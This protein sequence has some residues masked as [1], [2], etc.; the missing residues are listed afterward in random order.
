MRG[1]RREGHVYVT[2]R[3]IRDFDCDLD[4]SAI[5]DAWAA[6][7]GLVRLATSG[8]GEDLYFGDWT[9]SGR[10]RPPSQADPGWDRGLLVL[11]RQSEKCHVHLEAWVSAGAGGFPLL[12][13]R[14]VS[15]ESG[16]RGWAARS[17]GRRIVDDLLTN[18][19][20]PGIERGYL[21]RPEPSSQQGRSGSGLGAWFYPDGPRNTSGRTSAGD[22]LRQQ[23]RVSDPELGHCIL[24]GCSRW[25]IACVAIGV[26]V[27][28]FQVASGDLLPSGPP[29]L[30]SQFSQ[31]ITI[32]IGGLFFVGLAV[33]ARATSLLIGER[34]FAF[35]RPFRS[36]QAAW[37]NVREV[38]IQ[39][40]TVLV[41]LDLNGRSRRV[42]L[43]SDLSA[44][45]FVVAELMNE[46][47]GEHL[48]RI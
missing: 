16:M 45:P 21:S 2:T 14:E 7:H 46:S 25:W 10:K 35:R 15:L 6:R 13:P 24:V 37:P 31:S 29:R 1:T 20:Q 11:V 27:L 18:L 17:A 36:I 8:P 22:R 48:D 5:T 39:R 47:R 26:G 38:A 34:G 40:R 33:W 23:P 3:T 41:S 44:S 30:S 42:R 43:S 4:V 28:V 32:T 12:V 19:G 9:R